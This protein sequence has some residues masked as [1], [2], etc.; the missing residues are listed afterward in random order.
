MTGKFELFEYHLICVPLQWR[1]RVWR[2]SE[3]EI[4]F[5]WITLG[6]CQLK[7]HTT[8]WRRSILTCKGDLLSTILLSQIA[9]SP[10][11][12]TTKPLSTGRLNASSPKSQHSSSSSEPTYVRLSRWD[13][14]MQFAITWQSLSTFGSSSELCEEKPALI[15]WAPLSRIRVLG[16]SRLCEAC[17]FDEPLRAIVGC[18]DKCSTSFALVR[19][20]GKCGATP[21]FRRRSDCACNTEYFVVDT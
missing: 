1:W 12:F 18:V 17:V 20:S 3:D 4:R 10:S 5:M 21:R 16:A 15:V 11:Q 6:L 13:L 14:A 7:I 2:F 8:T 19:C 9:F